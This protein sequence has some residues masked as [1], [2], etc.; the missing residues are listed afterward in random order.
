MNWLNKILYLIA[1]CW[2]VFFFQCST[3]AKP[4]PG[5]EIRI[6][7]TGGLIGADPSKDWGCGGAMKIIRMLYSPLYSSDNPELSITLNF[8]HSRD[9]T[10][11]EFTLKKNCYFHSDPC[12]GY[13]PRRVNAYDVK[14]TFDLAKDTWGKIDLEPVNLIKEIIV[15]D[16]FHIEFILTESDKNFIN[17]LDKEMVYIIPPEAKERYGEN[18]S[19]HPIGCGSFRFES[20]ND[21]EIVLIKNKS[22]WAKDRW[23]QNLPYLDKIV[24]KFFGD[25][26]QCINALLNNEVDI[27]PL[28]GDVADLVFV[29]RENGVTIREDYQNLF[30]A[31]RC[32]FP[33]LTILLLNY[34]DN[35]TFKNRLIRKALN[36]AIN[37]EEIVKLLSMPFVAPAYGPTMRYLCGLKYEYNPQKAIELLKKAGYENGLSGLTFRHYPNPFSKRLAEVLQSQLKAI[38]IKTNLACATRVAALCGHPKWD[39]DVISIIYSDSTPSSHLHLY[40]SGSVAWVDFRSSLFD[41]LWKLYDTK[42]DTLLLCKMD[43]LV[44]EEPPFIFLY[45]SYPCFIARKNLES[46]DALLY[47]SPYTWW[48]NE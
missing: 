23:N 41:S 28:T 37:R 38:G 46:I 34:F 39:F 33:S 32:P 8:S 15:I 22:F 44:L 9:Y 25:A 14:Y 35:P 12:F 31:V 21:K 24:I 36:Y 43:S 40:Y 45:W 48:K 29:H 4:N 13:N 27:S 26:N 20:W 1:C 17:R 3:G 47:I 19:F 42:P 30:R 10:E 11:W 16:S 5:G 18:F 7:W 6:A 2:V